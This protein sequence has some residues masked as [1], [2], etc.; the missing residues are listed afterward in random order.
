MGVS[1]IHRLF[2]MGRQDEG[3]QGI[4]EI[5]NLEEPG[6]ICAFAIER[7]RGVFS[8]SARVPRTIQASGFTLS[9]GSTRLLY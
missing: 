5:L 8:V 1:G 6:P 7:S 4:L 2:G 3:K 9:A